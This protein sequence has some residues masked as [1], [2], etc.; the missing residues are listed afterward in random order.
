MEKAE[1]W[2]IFLSV[3]FWRSLKYEHIY[4]KPADDGLEL[5]RGIQEYINFYNNQRRHTSLKR[6]TPAESY[7]QLAA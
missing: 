3:R 1:R 4:L 5:F 6:Q 2:T 7:T